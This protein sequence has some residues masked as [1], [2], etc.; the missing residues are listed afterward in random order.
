MAKQF[1]YLI[2]GFVKQCL[3]AKQY[4]D[5]WIKDLVVKAWGNLFSSLKDQLKSLTIKNGV[6]YIVLHSLILS[7]DLRRNKQ[8]VVFKLQQEVSRLASGSC[9]VKDVVFC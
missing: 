2:Q 6:V 3:R 5:F 4:D 9:F 8:M 1:D 7:A